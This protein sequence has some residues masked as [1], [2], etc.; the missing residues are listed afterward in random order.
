MATTRY[1]LLGYPARHSKSPAMHNAAFKQAGIYAQYDAYEVAPNALAATFK[2]LVASGVAGFNV[3]MPFK[4]AIMLYLDDL[5]PL[6][7]RLSAVNTVVIRDG[8]TI[9][10]STDGAGFWRTLREPA[11][12][13]I[14]IGTGGAARAIMATAPKSVTLHVFNRQSERFPEKAA[15]VNDLAGVELHDLEEIGVYLPYADLIV[16]ATNVGMQS[17][18]SILSTEQFYETQPDVQV[19]DIIYK[20]EPTPFVAAARAA[21]RQA[22]DGLAMLIGQGALSFEQW[23]GQLPDINVMKQAIMSAE[24]GEE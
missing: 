23:T 19:V 15:M 24:E 22:D 3:T 21:G 6:A 10:D 9:G 17:D 16:N 4:E 1:G 2:S 14:L 7:R 20:K 11:D 13:V 18:V 12:Q 5:T 8:K